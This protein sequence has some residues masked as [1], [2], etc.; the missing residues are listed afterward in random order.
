M[1]SGCLFSLVFQA[2]FVHPQN[3]HSCS[4]CARVIA[5]ECGPQ[6]FMVTTLLVFLYFLVLPWACCFYCFLKLNI[7]FY[8]FIDLYM[9][10][11]KPICVL[12]LHFLGMEASG[13]TN[14]KCTT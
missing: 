8:F 1:V 10:K 9:S 6:L 11:Q 12:F 3:A 2:H 4:L 7:V 5:A 13:Y 14:Q